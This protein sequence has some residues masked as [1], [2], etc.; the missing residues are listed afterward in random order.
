MGNFVINKDRKTAG[1]EKEE[2]RRQQNKEEKE[3]E[4]NKCHSNSFMKIALL[5]WAIL[6]LCGLHIRQQ[7][8][9]EVEEGMN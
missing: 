2:R 7:K 9:R 6:Y 1:K 8:L 5:I 4:K 3:K